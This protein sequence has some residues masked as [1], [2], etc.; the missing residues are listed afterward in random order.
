MLC[1]EA[2]RSWTVDVLVSV[3]SE[4]VV[5][6]ICLYLAFTAGSEAKPESP[7]VNRPTPPE[8]RLEKEC[9]YHTLYF[10]VICMVS[11][12]GHVSP[13]NCMLWSCSYSVPCV[14]RASVH[15]AT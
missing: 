3:I 6:V 12:F 2:A 8:V 14:A 7:A 11:V 9:I 4:C 1:A 10:N 13:W 15:D 5:S